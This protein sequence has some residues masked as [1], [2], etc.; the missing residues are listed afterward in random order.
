MDLEHP[1]WLDASFLSAALQGGKKGQKVTVLEFNVSK[2]VSA[3]DNNSSCPY[4]VKVT[5][6]TGGSQD[7]LHDSLIV[8]VPLSKG[9]AAE[10]VKGGRLCINRAENLQRGFAKNAVEVGVSVCNKVLLLPGEERSGSE[11]YEGRR[12]HDGGQT[13]VVGLSTLRDCHEIFS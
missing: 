2:A 7:V 6:V 8:K 9:V 3:A 5:Y 12:I 10:N 1:S 4:R 13:Q 11:R